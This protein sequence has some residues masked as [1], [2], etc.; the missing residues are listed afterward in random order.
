MIWPPRRRIVKVPRDDVR[1]QMRD[2][3]PESDEVQLHR[4]EC[5]S[6]RPGGRDH[7]APVARCP[8]GVELG[9]LRDVAELPHDDAVARQEASAFESHLGER[10]LGDGDRVIVVASSERRAEGAVEASLP[11]VP[12]RRPSGRY[13]AKT[14]T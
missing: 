11:L 10:P 1:V 7:V 12:I 14:M 5:G 8:L 2:P 3:V 4:L 9:H 13:H 6:E